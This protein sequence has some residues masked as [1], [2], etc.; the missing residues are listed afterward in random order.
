MDLEAALARASHGVPERTLDESIRN[1][2]LQTLINFS[3]ALQRLPVTA[4]RLADLDEEAI[5]DVL[6]FLINSRWKAATGEAFSGEGKTDIQLQFQGRVAFTAELKIYGG[7]SAV[8]KAV[9]QLTSYLVWR[10]THAALVVIIR[11]R[12]D[13][14]AARD[15]ITAAVVAHDRYLTGPSVVNGRTQFSLSTC[16]ACRTVT[17]DLITIPLVTLSSA[18]GVRGGGGG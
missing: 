8:T 11:D 17:L 6:L 10:D 2:I 12:K 13:V 9:D 16:D 18:G 15:S 4:A 14:S 5:R 7:P 3:E 1:D